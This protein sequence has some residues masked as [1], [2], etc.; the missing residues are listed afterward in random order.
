MAT[1]CLMLAGCG[2]PIAALR[3]S[4]PS[5]PKSEAQMTEIPSPAST[6][7]SA[8]GQTATLYIGTKAAGFGEYPLIYGG[9]LTP[10]ALI[11]GI[12]DLTGWN[13]TLAINRCR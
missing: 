1:L 7:P 3:E 2:Q 12:E 10:E 9:E 4:I 13:L 5:N 8:D 11:Q 6:E